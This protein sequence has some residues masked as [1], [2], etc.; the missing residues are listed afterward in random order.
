[1]I[2]IFAHPLLYAFMFKEISRRSE[3]GN[4]VE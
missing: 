1:M 3:T 2:I 4:I